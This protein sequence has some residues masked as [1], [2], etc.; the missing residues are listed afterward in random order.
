MWSPLGWV[1]GPRSE[2]SASLR[3]RPA[4]VRVANWALIAAGR[5][6]QSFL[7]ILPHQIPS[8]PP[9]GTVYFAIDSGSPASLGPIAL[10]C[11][12]VPRV[13]RG[14]RGMRFVES[15]SIDWRS[16][17]AF[18]SSSEE[19]NH[20]T[21]FGPVSKSRTSNRSTTRSAFRQKRRS[22]LLRDLCSFRSRWRS[23][24]PRQAPA[25]VAGIGFRL[26][27]DTHWTAGK[28]SARRLRRGRSSGSRSGRSNCARRLGP[29]DCDQCLRSLRQRGEF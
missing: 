18:L 9:A 2:R 13:G 6:H 12:T 20:W 28:H 16:V 5:C 23:R 1:A 10:V 22:D 21:N 26:R 4:C 15:K 8:H 14:H 27:F 17:Q 3:L 29:R 19:Q 11:S 25:K 24:G 7:P